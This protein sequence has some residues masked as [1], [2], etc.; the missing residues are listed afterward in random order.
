MTLKYAIRLLFFF[1][2]LEFLKELHWFDG[3]KRGFQDYKNM[4]V[5]LAWKGL[6]LDIFIDKASVM[7]RLKFSLLVVSKEMVFW[8]FQGEIEV[9]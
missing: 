1:Y 6:L 9:D 8:L 3:Y 2:F 4:M 7:D 5:S